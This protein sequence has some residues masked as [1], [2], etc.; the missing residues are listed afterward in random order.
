MVGASDTE[1]T[2]L[3][4]VDVLGEWDFE[5]TE[6]GEAERVSVGALEILGIN[7]TEGSELGAIDADGL[8]LGENDGNCD[9]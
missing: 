8:V 5:G 1:G 7:D 2:I 6:L 9:G 3:G 4:S